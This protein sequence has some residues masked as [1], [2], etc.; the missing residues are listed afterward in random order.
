MRQLTYGILEGKYNQN[1]KE[2]LF[3]KTCKVVHIKL[4]MK[5]LTFILEIVW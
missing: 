4:N 1:W 3:S 2:D 5:L